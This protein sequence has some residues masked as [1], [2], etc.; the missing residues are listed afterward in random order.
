M[1]CF[2]EGTPVAIILLIGLLV[3]LLPVLS[4]SSTV[5]AEDSDYI[6]I[7]GEQPHQSKHNHSQAEDSG[8]ILTDGGHAFPLAGTAHQSKHNHS[9]AENG[10]W[11]ALARRHGG[12]DDVWARPLAGDTWLRLTA[13]SDDERWPA[14]S[15]DGTQLAYAARRGR[16]WDI[17][18]LDLAIGLERRL[19]TNPHFDGWPAWSPDGSRLAFASMRAGDLDIFLLDLG[20]GDLQ[21]L[22]AE[23]PAHDFAPAWHPEGD[24]LAFVTTRAGNHDV[25]LLTVSTGEATPLIHSPN[26]E[27]DPDW[28]PDGRLVVRIRAGRR[29]DVVVYRPPSGERTVLSTVG[30]VDAP[31]AD[32]AGS[33]VLWL[34]PRGTQTFL[35]SR[36][37]DA[38]SP[39]VRRGYPLADDVRDL[40][41]GPADSTLI[42]RRASTVP[43]EGGVRATDSP[44][45]TSQSE[46]VRLDDLTTGI[47]WLSSR[48]VDSF[49]DLRTRVRDEVGYDFLGEVSETVRPINY[50]SEDSDYLSWHKA[51][52][53]VDTLWDLGYR[54]GHTWLEIVREDR[55]G[56]VYWRV[57]L[58]CTA[59]DGSCGRPLTETPWDLS[60]NARW[61]EAPGSGGK[62]RGFV[63]GYYVDFTQRAA[64]AGWE[65]IAS[66]E[67][68]P[69]DW[70]T[71]KLALE[72]WHFQQTDGVN[73]W[74]AMQQVHTPTELEEWFAWSVLKDRD[75]P[76]WKVRA[77]GIPL[78][79]E[80]KQTGV[81]RVIP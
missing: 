52:R 57:Y 39:A 45:G 61:V 4:S 38:T 81:R 24:T 49:R 72:Y 47:P 69:F 60:Y 75:I 42:V 58:R 50:A 43:Q 5:Q 32:P 73:W 67:A 1:R 70:R 22:T 40:T 3:L 77:K 53:A 16:N 56:N 35:L 79:A 37:A 14:W 29:S 23:S 10:G 26:S 19:T 80:V 64:D 66:Y 76:L 25:Y 13:T 78:P 46:L 36:A 34:E 11:I 62:P 65:R 30:V 15:P 68:E 20:T 48:V 63:P 55:F 18:V 28:L 44:S 27:Q 12:Q 51:G 41:W 21:N 7:D 9:Q 71:N 54:G 59:Q 6:L 8:Y 33:D 2:A 31:T 17:Y 74:K